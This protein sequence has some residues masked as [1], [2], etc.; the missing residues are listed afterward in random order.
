MSDQSQEQV[1]AT[2]QESS[3]ILGLG[4]TGGQRSAEMLAGIRAELMPK[5]EYVAMTRAA[6]RVIGGLIVRLGRG[7]QA[8]ANMVIARPEAFRYLVTQALQGRADA[9]Y[10]ELASG[11]L[12]RAWQM[13]REFPQLRVTEIDL[14]EVIAEKQKSL[15]EGE[16]AF[17]AEPADAERRSGRQAVGRGLGRRASGRDH[18]RRLAAILRAG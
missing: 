2:A 8:K 1:S 6:G 4:R 9:H 11:F 10:V 13:A 18:C 3:G 7:D 15:R 12:P 16:A 5:P 14:P 17:A